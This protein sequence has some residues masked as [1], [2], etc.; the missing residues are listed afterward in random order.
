[1]SLTQTGVFISS[2]AMIHMSAPHPLKISDLT[3]SPVLGTEGG[4]KTT[5]AVFVKDIKLPNAKIGDF[6]HETI[7][8]MTFYSW[9]SILFAF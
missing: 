1:M 5:I 8:P 9:F 4:S 7:T 6:D 3:L 2:G